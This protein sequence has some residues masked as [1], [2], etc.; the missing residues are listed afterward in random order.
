MSS[1]CAKPPF[2]LTVLH[3]PRLHSLP[4]QQ[5]CPFL[6]FWSARGL[7]QLYV[8]ALLY[9]IVHTEK[10][11]DFSRSVMLYRVVAS[12]GMCFMG[13]FCAYLLSPHAPPAHPA[14][15]A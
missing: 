10:T 11:D 1:R 6:D 9:A 15:V 12:A 13:T 5:F 3:R 7:F 4:S 14:H 2:H 8:A